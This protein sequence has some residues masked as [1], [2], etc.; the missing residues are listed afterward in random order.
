MSIEQAINSI[1]SLSA[2]EQ[3][4]VVSAIWDSLPEDVSDL[5]P[6]SEKAILE[7]RL[8]KYKTNPD[9]VITEDELKEELAKRKST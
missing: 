5:M 8:L 1:S 9:D 6:V 3:I 7:D 2:S 4:Q